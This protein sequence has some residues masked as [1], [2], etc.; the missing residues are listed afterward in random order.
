MYSFLSTRKWGRAALGTAVVGSLWVTSGQASAA[1]VSQ[2]Y[3]NDFSSSATDFVVTGGAWNVEAEAYRNTITGVV[4]SSATVQVDNLGGAPASASNFR[5]SSDFTV[6]SFVGP[7]TT[8]GLAALGSTAN[9]SVSGSNDYYLA[10]LQFGAGVLRLFRI[11]STN[12]ELGT[13]PVG[14]LETGRTYQLQLDGTYLNSGAELQLDLSLTDLTT[15]T[16]QT[17]SR[18]TSTVL[19]GNHFGYRNRTNGTNPTLD[20]TFDNFSVTIP[21]PTTA[22]VLGCAAGLLALRRRRAAR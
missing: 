22:A 15:L 8:I 7:Q 6:N 1:L 16:R 21:E 13:L 3:V 5:I 2:P 20:A 4:S 18:T 9:L 10:D 19:T 14:T 12:T 17:L 11:A